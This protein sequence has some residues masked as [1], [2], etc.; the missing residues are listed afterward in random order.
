MT[1]FTINKGV[2]SG[3]E[4]I[5]SPNFNAR[6]KDCTVSGVVIHNISL[7]PEQFGQTNAAGVHHVKAFFQ[8]ALN[9]D[10]DPYFTT[11]HQMQVSAHLLIERDGTVTQFVNFNDRAWH[12]G[13]SCYL[14][15][16][17]CNDFTIG[18]E[19]EGSDTTAFTAAQYDVL[20]AIIK[21][22]YAAYPDTRRH[23]MGH[24]DIA[25]NRKTDPGVHFDWIKLREMLGKSE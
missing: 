10:D 20:A 8:N 6:P 5:A 12:A 19:L 17:N 1:H 24:S 25:P 11:I 23:L 4:F 14:G 7:P 16:A 13:Q 2:L 15:R 21:A 3:A 22:I 18:I 9:P